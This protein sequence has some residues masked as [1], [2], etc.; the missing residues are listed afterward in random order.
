MSTCVLHIEHTFPAQ[1]AALTPLITPTHLP[2]PQILL[3][4]CPF[5][6]PGN[7]PQG[8]DPAAAAA[9]AA[10][11]AVGSSASRSARLGQFVGGVMNEGGQAGFL[12]ALRVG[13]AR[14]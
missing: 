8:S 4:V 7:A 5:P 10:A 12:S 13:K 3:F 2:S 14:S 1:L 6:Q 9:A 11:V